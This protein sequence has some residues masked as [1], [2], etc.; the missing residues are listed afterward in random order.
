MNRE[1][2]LEKALPLLLPLFTEAGYELPEKLHVSVG[3]PSTRA[4]SSKNRRIGECWAGR[5]SNDGAPHI[6]ISPVIDDALRVLGVLIHELIHASI[7]NEAGHKKPFVEAMKL[8][9]LE[10][11]PTATTESDALVEKLKPIAELLGPYPQPKFDAVK[12]QEEKDKKKQG[13]RLLKA[14]CPN[15]DASVNKVYTIRITKVHL[16]SFG[17]PFCPKCKSQLVL[18]GGQDESSD[19]AED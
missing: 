17:A 15:G 11:K 2:W 8:L 4:L 6:F 18:E 16:D 7:G 10:G 9:G 5:V 3:F 19:S 14:V 12:L 13:T 1:T